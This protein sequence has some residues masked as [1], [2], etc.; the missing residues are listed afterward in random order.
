M[1]ALTKTIQDNLIRLND[2]C[3]NDIQHID[4]ASAMAAIEA[5]CAAQW[6]AGWL[7]VYRSALQSRHPL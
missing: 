1:E 2:F 6:L 3:G 7:N 4:K 5:Q